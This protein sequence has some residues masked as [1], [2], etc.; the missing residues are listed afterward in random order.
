MKDEEI[1]EFLRK[2]IE[3]EKKAR[4][5]ISYFLGMDGWKILFG[6]VSSALFVSNLFIPL[7]WSIPEIYALRFM[8]FAFG[9]ILLPCYTAWMIKRLWERR[10]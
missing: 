2:E 7:F 9:A 6:V 1:L 5:N 4:W 10:T 8:L 3:Q